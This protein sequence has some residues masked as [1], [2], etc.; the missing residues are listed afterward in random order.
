VAPSL[1]TAI[2]IIPINT[3]VLRVANIPLTFVLRSHQRRKTAGFT[4]QR[5]MLQTR[6]AK[7]SATHCTDWSVKS[8]G[9]ERPYSTRARNAAAA[10]NAPSNFSMSVC[11]SIH[12]HLNEFSP[13]LIVESFTQICTSR[14]CLQPDIALHQ[15]HSHAFL[16]ASTA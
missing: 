12:D 8:A 11:S 6:R 4:S 2:Y 10:K 5:L 9:E 7:S 13:N 15:V 3:L 16:P 14:H 1:H